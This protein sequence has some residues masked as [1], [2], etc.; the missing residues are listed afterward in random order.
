MAVE[1]AE[2]AARQEAQAEALKADRA[3]SEAGREAPPE[4]TREADRTGRAWPGA[5]AEM[6]VEADPR[7]FTVTASIKAD[8]TAIDCK[9]DGAQ[10][11]AEGQVTM[12]NAAR[13]DRRTPLC[14]PR[15]SK[16]PPQSI[17]SKSSTRTSKPDPP[18]ET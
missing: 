13:G 6:R 8:L 2:A 17:R 4:R 9:L 11:G 5:Q 18:R 15:P 10:M 16:T 12:R 14:A 1:L 3:S 7:A